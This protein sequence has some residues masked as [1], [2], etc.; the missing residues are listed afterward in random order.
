MSCSARRTAALAALS[1][2]RPRPVSPAGRTRPAGARARRKPV[3]GVQGPAAV[4][5]RRRGGRR[6]PAARHPSAGVAVH[7]VGRESQQLGEF[8]GVGE[9]DLMPGIARLALHR[10]ALAREAWASPGLR[11]GPD[12]HGR[13]GPARGR[14]SWRALLIGARMSRNG[15]AVIVRAIGWRSSRRRRGRTAWAPSSCP[16]RSFL[17][18][19]GRS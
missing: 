5:F 3:P 4:R 14:R 17:C 7:P 13:S 10:S 19:A 2:R 16:G 8:A 12:H 15:G 11:G 9:A 18:R 6:M 1:W